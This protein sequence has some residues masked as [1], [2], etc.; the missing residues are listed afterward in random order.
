MQFVVYFK[1]WKQFTKFIQFAKK[2]KVLLLYLDEVKTLF[3]YYIKYCKF[4]IAYPSHRELE[5]NF[6]F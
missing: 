3:A 6:L 2:I 4:K 1:F 5:N